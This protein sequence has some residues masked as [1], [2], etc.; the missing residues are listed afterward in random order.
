VDRVHGTGFPEIKPW[1][2]LSAI[3]VEMVDVVPGTDGS[4]L[5]SRRLRSWCSQNRKS[6]LTFTD[7]PSLYVQEGLGEVLG[8]GMEPGY[9]AGCEDVT[10]QLKKRIQNRCCGFCGKGTRY[11]FSRNHA[12]GGTY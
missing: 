2:P 10:E 1:R 7:G 9:I 3:P 6:S 5:P 12:L 8:Q 11:R 4:S